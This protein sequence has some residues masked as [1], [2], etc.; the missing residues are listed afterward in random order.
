MHWSDHD[1]MAIRRHL[2]GLPDPLGDEPGEECGAWSE[3][4]EDCPRAWRC[5]G[6]MQILPDHPD[7][8][9]H[10]DTCHRPA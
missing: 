9:V 10:C 2:D 8:G 5:T 6:T 3:P 7:E 1:S 4:D